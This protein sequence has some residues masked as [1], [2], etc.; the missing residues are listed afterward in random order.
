MRGIIL[1]LHAE[2]GF[3][4][5]CVRWFDFSNSSLSRPYMESQERSKGDRY[6]VH[7]VEQS[8]VRLVA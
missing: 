4:F 6:A 7:E 5:A 3:R 1:V 2:L 8:G